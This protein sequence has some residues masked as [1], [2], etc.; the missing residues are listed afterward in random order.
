MKTTGILTDSHSGISQE[1]AGKLGIRVLPMP[2]YMEGKTCYEG[3]DLSREEFFEKLRSGIDVSTSQPV[4]QDVTDLWDEMLKEYEEIL[5]LPISSG[6]SGSCMTARAMAQEPGYEG[7]VFVADCGRVSTP[8]HRT[9]LDALELAEKGYGAE[10]ICRILEE[11]RENMSIYVT[12]STLE[13]L[14]KG[15]RIKPSVATL[16]SILNIKPVMQFGVGTLDVYQ[17]TRGMK[18]ARKTMIEAMRNDLTVKFK[19]AYETGNVYLL[20]ASSSSPEVTAEWVSEIK[21]AFPGMDVMCDDLSLGL[22][23]HIGPD[24]LG[25]GCSCRPDGMIDQL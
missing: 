6:L 24:G 5:Y 15:G 21:E 23:C 17:K 2:F 18:K 19:D 25:I 14:K 10:K 22:C 11:S 4:P 1:E 13:Y 12:P 9:V 3:I 16:G 8:L 20:A 7:K